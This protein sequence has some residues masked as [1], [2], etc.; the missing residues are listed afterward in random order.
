MKKQ[1]LII[2]CIIVVL[3]SLMTAC[4]SGPITLEPQ[5]IESYQGIDLTPTASLPEN[6]IK[7][8]QEI[9]LSDYILEIRG[10]VE[11]TLSLTY[12][13]VLAYTI[14]EKQ[15]TLNC[16]QG[17]KAEILWEGVLLRDI[18]ADAGITEN[19]ATV[20]FHAPDG[21]TAA[22]PLDRFTEKDI[23]LAHKANGITLPP[24][25]GFPFIVVAEEE[26]GYKWARWVTEIEISSDPDFKDF[27]EQRDLSFEL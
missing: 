6:S 23:L 8:I 10:E 14:Y 24:S 22:L 12:E 20:I 5:E 19:A 25:L 27:W 2:I 16:I 1:R 13:E 21:Y 11:N 17:W 9:E 7:G 4:K 15:I 26:I 3:L 18:F